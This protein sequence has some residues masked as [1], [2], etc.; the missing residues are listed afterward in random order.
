V[1]KHSRRKEDCKECSTKRCVHLRRLYSCI[2]CGGAGTCEHKVIRSTCRQCGGGSMCKHGKRRCRCNQCKVPARRQ[3]TPKRSH[4]D[5][6]NAIVSLEQCLF[7]DVSVMHLT[8]ADLNVVTRAVESAKV[9]DLTDTG[10][11]FRQ[12]VF[13]PHNCKSSTLSCR[14]VQAQAYQDHYL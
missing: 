6:P 5:R 2:D 11:T 8:S 13:T 4:S 14:S 3:Q 7:K 1:C 10:R 12:Y 9:A